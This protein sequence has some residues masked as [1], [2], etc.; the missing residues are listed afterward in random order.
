M[1]YP[2]RIERYWLNIN[3]RNIKLRKNDRIEERTKQLENK[4][5]K[6]RKWK[7]KFSNM[8][9]I[10][11]TLNLFNTI[12]AIQTKE[13]GYLIWKFK[14]KWKIMGEVYTQQNIITTEIKYTNRK[15]RRK[16]L[17]ILANL[18]DVGRKFISDNDIH[19]MTLKENLFPLIRLHLLMHNNNNYFESIHNN[20]FIFIQN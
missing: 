5:D 16:K 10:T 19:E 3:E 13:T 9:L 7:E 8:N 11:N 20:K 14:R 18:F 15:K 6:F 1:L 12:Y 2:E 4:I 17:N